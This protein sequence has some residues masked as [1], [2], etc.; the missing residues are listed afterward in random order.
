MTGRMIPRTLL[1]MILGVVSLGAQGQVT[2]DRLLKMLRSAGIESAKH[3]LANSAA[4]AGARRS[5][6]T[7]SCTTRPTRP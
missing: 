3:H 2:F 4:T 7:A 6:S 5:G 1:L